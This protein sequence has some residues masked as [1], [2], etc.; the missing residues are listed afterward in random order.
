METVKNTKENTNTCKIFTFCDI[1]GE[2][3][4]GIFKKNEINVC[5]SRNIMIQNGDS[6]MKMFSTLCG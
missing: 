5:N 6:Y 4:G 2:I 1:H 3:E